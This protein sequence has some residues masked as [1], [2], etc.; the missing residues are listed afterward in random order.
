MLYDDGNA[1]DDAGDAAGDAESQYIIGRRFYEAKGVPRDYVASYAWFNVSAAN[2]GNLGSRDASYMRDDVVGKL[3]MPSQIDEAQ[4]L[5]R[6][7][8]GDIEANLDKK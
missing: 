4:K 8:I 1:G 6:Q 7:F 5:S 2:S 3:M